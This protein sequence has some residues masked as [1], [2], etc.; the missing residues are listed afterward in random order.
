M[1]NA[2]WTP[3]VDIRRYLCVAVRWIM[4]A[5]TSCLVIT[6]LSDGEWVSSFIGIFWWAEQVVSSVHLVTFQWNYLSF[7]TPRFDVSSN[8]ETGYVFFSCCQLLFCCPLCLIMPVDLV[9]VFIVD[10]CDVQASRTV[11]HKLRGRALTGWREYF[12]RHAHGHH[13]LWTA[14]RLL[15]G[16]TIPSYVS[17]VTIV[18]LLSYW[19]MLTF[20]FE[21]KT[22]TVIITAATA[23]TVL[24]PVYRTTLVSHYPHLRTGDFVCGKLL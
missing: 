16:D 9:P 15:T 19:L 23:T 5:M 7:L 18:C 21:D 1:P 12:A 17:T 10:M 4:S 24:W 6:T 8:S 22:I 20:K 3:A 2:W 11:C 14:M 13:L